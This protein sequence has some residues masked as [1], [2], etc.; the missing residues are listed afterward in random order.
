[1]GTEE[2]K[3]QLIKTL[4]IVFVIFIYLRVQQQIELTNMSYVRNEHFV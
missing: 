4:N 1:M 2:D 3:N